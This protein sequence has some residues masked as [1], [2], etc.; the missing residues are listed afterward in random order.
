LR[1]VE[2]ADVERSLRHIEKKGSFIWHEPQ[3]ILRGLDRIA[4][5]AHFVENLEFQVPQ[6]ADLRVRREKL[7]RSAECIIF[8]AVPI[9][10]ERLPDVLINAQAALRIGQDLSG[11]H[12]RRG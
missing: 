12:S 7:T 6:I 4:L 11:L 9:P 2:I 10:R 3:S 8:L 5:A 1:G